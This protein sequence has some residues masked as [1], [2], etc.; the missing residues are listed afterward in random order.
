[1]TQASSPWF[2][3]QSMRGEKKYAHIEKN[4][5]NARFLSM[6]MRYYTGR[7]NKIDKRGCSMATENTA[8]QALATLI[9]E[10]ISEQ[11]PA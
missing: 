2:Y 4:S 6:R 9:T 11:L 1:M 10:G 3:Y 8:A 7:E 5:A